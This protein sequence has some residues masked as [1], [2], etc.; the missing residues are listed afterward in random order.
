MILNHQLVKAENAFISADDR[1]FRYGDGVFDTMR[2]HGGVPYQ[3]DWHKQRLSAGLH[4]L[5]IPCDLTKLHDEVQALLQANQFKNGLLRIQVTRGRGGRGYLPEP[6]A[7]PTI[8]IETLPAP[9]LS[10]SPVTLWQPADIEKIS[11]HALPIQY[12]LC[13]GIN[14]T[15]ARLR[16]HDEGCFDSLLLDAN[17]HVCETSSANIFW[18]K[19]R[20]TYT[21]SLSTGALEGATRANLLRI[22][23]YPV[24][25]VEVPLETLKEAEAVV[26]CNTAWG[27]LPVAQL[28]P[29]GYSWKSEA[30]AQKLTELL[31]QDIESYSALH[32]QRW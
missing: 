5:R 11:P 24:R 7:I 6:N 14:S 3:F 19:E 10:S 17:H 22:S 13:Q 20:V 32:A 15:L 18:L 16:A 2:I 31:Q 30:F 8:I 21:P 12:K 9:T 29:H 1:G 4:A 25:Q 28:M 27:V 26:I 23:P